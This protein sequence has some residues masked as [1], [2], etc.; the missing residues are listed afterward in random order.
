MKNYNYSKTS[1]P[2]GKQL[3]I[4]LLLLLCTS[5]GYSQPKSTQERLGYPKNAK[6]VIIHADD[7]GVSHSEN[8]ASLSSLEIGC[9][10]SASVMVPCPWFPEIALYAKEHPDHDL[11]LHI[12]LTSEWKDYKWGSIT[13]HSKVPGLI[14][15]NG[16][17]YSSADSVLRSASGAEVE[18][19]TRNQVLRA[20]RFGLTPTHLDAHMFTT[21]NSVD[22][23]KVYIKIGREFKIPVFIPR[24]LEDRLHIKLETVV[25]DKEVIV[26]NVITMLSEDYKIGPTNFYANSIRNMKPGLNYFII[27]TAYDTD[28]MRAVTTGFND[29]GS[30]WRQQ[31][32]DFFSSP[33][34]N[35]LLKESN[36]F[37]V[38]WKEM[39]DKITRK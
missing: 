39:R 5:F 10:S 3:D 38:S 34:C 33:E 25:S 1:K 31:E 16:F 11:G 21:L 4:I 30:A 19:E 17:L 8:A 32:Y 2:C 24:F 37:V 27:H 14:N 18:E 26:D 9:V 20:I 35:K 29:W 6:L 15:K 36:I 22:F 12:T 28:E 13:P 7:L 23:L